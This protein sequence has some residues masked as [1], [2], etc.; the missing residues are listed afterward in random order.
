MMLKEFEQLTGIYPDST[1]YHIIEE[2]Y[3]TYEGDKNAFCKAYLNNTEGLAERIRIKVDTFHN[4][5]ID[6]YT[7]QIAELKESLE[8]LG[9]KLEKEEEWKPHGTL[10]G[11]STQ[12][13]EKLKNACKEDRPTFSTQEIRKI[14]ERECGFDYSNV[15]IIEELSTYEINRHNRLRTV[16]KE[17]RKPLYY[18]SDWNYIRFNAGYY[19]YEYINGTLQFYKD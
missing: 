14:I 15:K 7:K 19:Q 6:N 13:Y 4:Q 16:G 3:Y 5:L 10:S 9:Q 17:E 11:M 18:A 1:T 2:E 8:N 12:S